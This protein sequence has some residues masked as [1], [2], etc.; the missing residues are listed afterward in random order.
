METPMTYELILTQTHDRVGVIQFNRPKALNALNREMMAEVMAAAEAFDADAA[1]GCIVITGNQR[2]FAA[3]ADIKEMAVATPV[4]MLD[5]P[6]IDYWDRLRRIS[7]PVVA[8]V[9]GFALGG[10]CE[11][12]MACDMIIASETAQ[13]GQPEINLGV[14][15]GAG[16][17]QRMTRAV[18]KALAMEIVLN[19]RFLSAEEAVRFG[20]ANKVVPAESYLEEAIRFA[21]QIA[22]RAPVALR[23]GKEAVNA[24]FETTLQTGLA[25]ER[26][27]FYMLFA[28][29]DQKEG[30]DAFINK[31]KAEWQGK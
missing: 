8:A 29:A 25:Y 10:G 31:R 21:A 18:G 6:F 27:L 9:S 14:I 16:G 4:T 24:A 19:G 15:P 30:M 28:T 17:T 20:L 12:A 5:N 26:R 1:I 23:L 7:K 3:G 22:A 2:A 11:L 13:F